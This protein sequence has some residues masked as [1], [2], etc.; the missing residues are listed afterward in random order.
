VVSGG[1]QSFVEA[2][3]VAHADQMPLVTPIR[4][5]RRRGMALQYLHP[6]PREQVVDHGF[7]HRLYGVWAVPRAPGAM[8]ALPTA[9]PYLPRMRC[10]RWTLSWPRR[11]TA[12]VHART[13]VDASSWKARPSTP[14]AALKHASGRGG[15]ADRAWRNGPLCGQMPSWNRSTAFFATDARTPAIPHV[16]MPEPRSRLGARS[17]AHRW[18]QTLVNILNGCPRGRSEHWIV[19]PSRI[20][21]GAHQSFFALGGQDV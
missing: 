14:S 13:V 11:S 12:E 8:S 6:A 3:R 16:R 2:L 21:S 18:L 7:Y 1:S 4:D 19:R 5:W 9:S 20:E 17:V 15:D 10:G